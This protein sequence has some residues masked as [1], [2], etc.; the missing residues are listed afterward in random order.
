MPLPFPL[1]AASLR[2]PSLCHSASERLQSTPNTRA[3]VKPE[4]SPSLRS[5]LPPECRRRAPSPPFEGPKKLR[6][7]ASLT[8]LF[9]LFGLVW[10]LQ[11][12]CTDLKETV[13]LEWISLFSCWYILMDLVQDAKLAIF[14]LLIWD[15]D[16]WLYILV[17]C[18]SRPT[19]CWLMMRH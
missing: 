8:A 14:L 7:I 4:P 5:L 15:F 6:C 16:D 10:N 9:T 17:L 12:L 11:C 3:R 13:L 19:I 1:Q 2:R 18:L